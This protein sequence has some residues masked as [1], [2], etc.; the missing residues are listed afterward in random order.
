MVIAAPLRP[1]L[2]RALG[3]LFALA[4]VVALLPPGWSAAAGTPTHPL[5]QSTYS[6]AWQAPFNRPDF[7]PLERRPAISA[8]RPHAEWVGRLILPPASP[9]GL[10]H[11]W[12][13]L[14]VQQAPPHQAGLIG[15]I[16][17]LEWSDEPQLQELVRRVTTDIRFGR[18]ASHSRA[19]G[20]VLP[21]RLDGRRRVGPLQSLAGAHPHDD[22]LVAL[23]P[24]AL[25]PG[26]I[27]IDRPPL[28]ITGRWSALVQF[29]AELPGDRFRVR[30]FNPTTGRFDGALDTIRVPQQPRDRYGR[31]MS[32]PRGLVGAPAGV[33]GW[34]VHGAPD[35][36]G[37]F[38]V[39][40]LEPRALLRLPAQRQVD[41]VQPGLVFVSEGNWADTP[42]RRGHIGRV[43]LQG[44]EGGWQLGD[45]ALVMHSFGGI[46]GRL[47]EPTPMAT[48]TGHFAFGE[49]WVVA[50][51]FTGEPRFEIHYH[52]IYANNPNGIV[53]GRQD[54]SAFSGD[55]Q[56]GWMGT[57]PISDALIRL[58]LHPAVADRFL[59]ELSLQAEVLMARYRSGDGGGVALVTPATSCVQDSAQALELAIAGLRD[60]GPGLTSLRTGLRH[61][62]Q[63]FGLQRSD[64]RHNGALVAMAQ[65]QGQFQR[66][67]LLDGILSWR[68]MIPRRGYDDLA[69]L[70]LNNGASLRVLRTNQLPGGDTAIAPL[71]PTLLF[72]RIPP[73]SLV[74]RRS[75]DALFT[76][77]TSATLLAGAPLGVI[78][79][80][81]ALVLGWW[82]RWL[83]RRWP[84]PPLKLLW[85][86]PRRLLGLLLLPALL[87]EWLFRVLLL[88]N[89]LEGFQQPQLLG[90]AALSLGLFVL[91]HPLAAMS[92]YRPGR[93]LFLQKPFLLQCTWLGLACTVLYLQSGS[94]WPPVLLHWLA[95]VCWLEQLE[96][97][98][99]LSTN[100]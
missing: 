11:D 16:L 53:A 33:D 48:V 28:Q 34:Y 25:E 92:W 85:Q 68:T 40:A 45:R 17:R 58:D 75:T 86:A 62:L 7:Y 56:R 23:Q 22:L 24:L 8:Y 37:L 2:R 60:P 54:W 98:N 97:R 57:R 90:W 96:G 79:G 95:V 70:M 88:P 44:G 42:Q 67:G 71:P 4:L 59:R 36:D 82:S 94:L 89:R 65:P 46:G 69:A 43:Q 73:L 5:R 55:L 80:A 10:A 63:P 31:W 99:Q 100:G 51:P 30:H 38:T 20:N 50:D 64:W 39:Q 61:L 47:G 21:D 27:V 84:L 12:V 81:G 83:P 29:E 1:L 72:G 78:Y 74:L 19:Q 32:T 41:G 91:Y 77:L 49:A 76:P 14:E 93:P 18:Q 52:Q 13:W 15:Q 35:A 26:R 6:L 9:E 87:E 3:A 66:G